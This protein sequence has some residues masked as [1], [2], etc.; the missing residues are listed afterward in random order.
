MP[1]HVLCNIFNHKANK[2]HR[3]KRI[4]ILFGHLLPLLGIML[5]A[6]LGHLY[7]GSEK[8]KILMALYGVNTLL[9][10][11]PIVGLYW[12]LFV[13]QKGALGLY[14]CSVVLK[15][16]VLWFLFISKWS[17]SFGF[18]EIQKATLMTPF[19]LALLVE[20][21]AFARF[22]SKEYPTAK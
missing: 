12:A 10:A 11:F 1:R 17:T 21:F 20:I 4:G 2:K 19:F 8:L 7:L 16:I 13:A 5:G 18:E 15:G 9:A 6:F 22:N 14:L 3:V